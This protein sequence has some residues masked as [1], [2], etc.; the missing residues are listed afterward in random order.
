MSTIIIQLFSKMSKIP[1][2]LR[3]FKAS[4]RKK[5]IEIAEFCGCKLQ[6]VSNWMSEEYCPKKIL[7]RHAKALVELTDGYITMR[8]CGWK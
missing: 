8:D 3:I 1:K 4:E 7:K 6:A 5:N 2:K